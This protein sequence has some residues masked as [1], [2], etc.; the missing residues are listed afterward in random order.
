LIGLLAATLIVA[1]LLGGGVFYAA[2]M[3]KTEVAAALGPRGE[4]GSINVGFSEVEVR[5]LRIRAAAGWPAG[6]E[7]RAG[8]VVIVP[9]LRALLSRQFRVAS[10]R[11]EDAYLS[12]L[13][14]PGGKL[15]VLPSLLAAPGGGQG[16]GQARGMPEIVFGAIKL[17][18]CAIDFFDATVRQPAHKL[19]VEQAS[20]EIG[21]IALP[22]LAGKTA[23]A[24]QGVVKGAQRDGRLNVRGWA[25]IA[26]RDSE[27]SVELRGV[28]LLAFQPYLIRAAETGVKRGS[29]DLDLVSTVSNKRLRAPG[30]VTLSD[31]E[32]SGGGS[33]MGLSRGAFVAA[34][35]DRQGR[36]SV[37]FVIEGNL[38][39]PRF[40]LNENFSGRVGSA[41]GNT[42]G[43]SLEGLAKGVGTVGSSAAK[44]VGEAVGKLF[45]R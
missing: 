10:I 18:N 14:Q 38:D 21:Y 30:N 6:E 4:V 3:L 11:V 1:L 45:G 28:D 42:L 39:D 43:I 13:R 2:R 41:V 19:R 37:R 36:I 44:G 15:A 40:S 7:L 22:A 24:V 23:I 26:T 25:E 9:D 17:Q 29:L 16:G 20:A 35:K 34:M 33:F 31:L 32:L 27:L 5:D 12:M 8:R